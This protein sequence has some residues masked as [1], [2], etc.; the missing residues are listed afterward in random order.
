MPRMLSLV[1]KSLWIILIQFSFC[2]ADSQSPLIKLNEV[3]TGM[4]LVEDDQ[5]GFYYEIPKLKTDVK[6]KIDGMVASATVDQ[7]FTNDGEIPIEAIY[8]FPLPEEAAIYEMQMLIGNRLIES[9]VKKKAEAKK[10]YTKA[11]KEGKRASLTEQERP[12]IFTN[13]VANIMPGDTI[14]VRLK[15]V[16]HVRYTNGVFSLRFPTVVGPRYIPGKVV[17]GYSGSGWSYDT[18]QVEDASR[19]TPP[20]LLHGAETGNSVSLVVDLNAGLDIESV[21][22]ITHTVDVEKTGTGKRIISLS[23]GV[24]IPNRDFVLE[25]KIK[26]GHEPKAALFSAQKG[27]DTYFMLMAVPNSGETENDRLLKE[28]IY[29]IDISGSMK[30]ASI[31]QAKSSLETAIRQLDEK[32]HFNIVAFNDSY[33][34]FSAQTVKAGKDNKQIAYMFIRNLKAEGGT[35][36]LS[37]L[38]EGM[39]QAQSSSAVSMIFLITDGSVGNETRILQ[40]INN[41]LGNAR[42]FPIGIGSA[43]NSFLLRKAAEQ[44]R[45]TFTYI[46][47]PREVEEKMMNL[48]KKIDS[49]VLTNIH[50]SID[51]EVDLVPKSVPDLFKGEPLLIFGKS[52]DLNNKKVTLTGR[53]QEGII[54]LEMP[55]ITDTGKDNPA[56][57]TLWAR[58]KISG[59]MNEYRLGDKSVK[60]DIVSMAIDHRLITKFTSFVAVENLIV[61]P[62]HDLASLAIPVDLPQGWDYEAVFGNPDAYKM[63]TASL[64]GDEIQLKQKKMKLPQTAT[65]YPLQFILGLLLIGLSEVLT[66]FFFR[67]EK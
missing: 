23:K 44:G 43:P 45:G 64:N 30:G 32:D 13:S 14:I 29:I 7:M 65:S 37:A 56:I 60:E 53:T 21:Q 46:S 11:K 39:H 6:I 28:M 50:L 12:N 3:E 22:S 54:S 38:N 61:N 8:V 49:P 31:R 42:L 41:K 34:T 47:S 57:S 20:V 24:D 58:K 1:Y 2:L 18:D 9:E 15:Y 40:A 55:I 26:Q 66:R 63:R 36:V 67:R 62:K 5:E 51:G 19:I 27:T 52:A 33:H 10:I 59:L 16:D 25:Y 4:L 35:E 48:L 17:T